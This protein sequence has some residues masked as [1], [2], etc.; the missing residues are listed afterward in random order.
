MIEGTL[1]V[2]L[3]PPYMGFLPKTSVEATTTSA[4]EN[5]IWCYCTL[6]QM[7]DFLVEL[8]LIHPAQQLPTRE[9]IFRLPSRLPLRTLDKHGLLNVRT[10]EFASASDRQLKHIS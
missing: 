1:V 3:D 8:D 9:Y 10:L 2:N 5:C 6:D 7:R 4:C